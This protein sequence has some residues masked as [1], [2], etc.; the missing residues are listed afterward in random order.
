MGKFMEGIREI[1]NGE[2]DGER[3]GLAPAD[4]AILADVVFAVI[5]V[6]FTPGPLPALQAGAEHLEAGLQHNLCHP[7]IPA[8]PTN[9]LKKV[10]TTTISHLSSARAALA[11]APAGVVQTRVPPDL[12]SAG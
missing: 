12:T 7:T 4:A 2:K 1:P 9:P 8:I 6:N 11:P 3:M 5:D 10:P